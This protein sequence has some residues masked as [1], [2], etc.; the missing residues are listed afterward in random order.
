MKIEPRLFDELKKV[1]ADFGDRYFVG[2]ELNR[3][4]LSEDLRNYDET[5]LE[6]LFQT[7]FIKQHFIKE[8]AGQKLFQIEQLEEAI[9]YN[10]YWDT[11]YTKYEN[12]IGLASNGKFLEECQDVVL[13]F[14]FK[15]GVLTASMTKED[16]ED[17]YDDAFL[18]EVIEKDEID[19]LFD[20]K[21]FVNSKRYDK[22]G[23]SV[24]TEFNED[25]DNLIIKGNNLLAL[26]AIKEKYAGKV[27]VIYID[28]PYNTGS[29]SFLY[30]DKFNHSAWL[31][32]MKN[33]L[34]VAKELL[35]NDGMIFVQTDD[36]EHAYLKVLMDSIFGQIKY[37]N[38][39]II[40]A[41]A[42]SGASGGG[43]DKRLKKNVEFLLVYAN[44]NA[45]IKIQQKPFLLSEY[46]AERKEQGKSFAYSNV[47][48]NEGTL[49]KIGETLDGR[50]EVIELYDVTGYETKSVSKLAKEENISEEEI[51][52]KYLDK[53]YTTENAQTSIRDRV[54]D[55]V[56]DDGYTI[57]RYVPVSGKNKGKVTDVGFI[58]TT[59]RLISF[60]SGTSYVEEGIAYKTEKAG[61]LWEDISWSSIKNEGGVELSN[62]KKPEKLLQRIIASGSE[63]KDIILD[64]F[65]G[66][67]ST[68]ATAMKMNRRFIGIEQM[69]YINEVSVS[70]LQKVI[71][72]EQGGISKDVNWQGGGSFV[73]TELM[74]KNMGYLQDIIHAKTLDDLKV[75]YNRMLEGTDTMEPADISFRADLD[76]IDWLEGFNENKRL[77]IK[78]LDKN[79]LYYNYS[80]I[81]D[82]NVRELIS[83]EDYRF[84]K[85][86]YKGGE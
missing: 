22:N 20:K 69:D 70:R 35:S 81:D 4:K 86:F 84:N 80:E 6:K 68:Q 29:D 30:N 27:K 62:G 65:M 28:P 39:V 50:G 45:Q 46:I 76:K 73:Y 25:T 38:T 3:S 36:K 53:I 55:A 8:V 34:E 85:Q 17:S 75:V 7:D 42:S 32:F 5:L 59:K 48:I 37:L 40:K 33:R 44:E 41:K 71:A 9:L 21:I 83:D 19:R 10:D 13:D 56:Q 51:Y 67:A 16:N 54:R 23:D 78:L 1:L 11:S 49:S 26:H 60:L 14:P 66:S 31:T 64:F 58:G 79:G 18:N 47:L 74:P 82:A 24:V 72:G 77:L 12:R 43:E 61:T 63:E 57:A 52:V 2:E 15:D